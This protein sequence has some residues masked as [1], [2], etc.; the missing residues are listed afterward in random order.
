M[1]PNIMATLPASITTLVTDS[2]TLANDVIA[3]KVIVV[4]AVIGF[5][6]VLWLRRKG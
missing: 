4:G 3:V 6:F 2:T 1:F 5:A